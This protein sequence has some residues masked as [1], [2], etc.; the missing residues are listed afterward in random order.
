MGVKFLSRI[1][2]GV[3]LVAIC[4]VEE[5]DSEEGGGGSDESG[6]GFFGG[7]DAGGAGEDNGLESVGI[8]SGG[9]GHEGGIITGE[10]SPCGEFFFGGLSDPGVC[11]G[12]HVGGEFHGGGGFLPFGGNA[13]TF[14][15]TNFHGGHIS[16]DGVFSHGF[17]GGGEA[18]AGG[19]FGAVS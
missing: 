12:E 18:A 9:L 16:P 10:E 4:S 13:H 8:G 14:L 5:S 19:N 11:H 3:V 1:K 6:G 17:D 2:L 7:I 15:D